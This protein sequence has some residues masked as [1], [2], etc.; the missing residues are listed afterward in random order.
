MEVFDRCG[1]PQSGVTLHFGWLMWLR[2][3]VRQRARL[4]L[5][6]VGNA[7]ILLVCKK[8]NLSV[9]AFGYMKKLVGR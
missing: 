7:F 2:R 5:R 1:V 3:T 8:K 6:R 9:V 4:C